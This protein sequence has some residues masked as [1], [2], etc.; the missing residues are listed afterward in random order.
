MAH[1]LINGDPLFTL[2]EDG[3]VQVETTAGV[4]AQVD[5]DEAAALSAVRS[6]SGG[7]GTMGGG[8][9]D[10]VL[11]L[12]SQWYPAEQ[13]K[14]LLASL[15]SKRLIMDR[16]RRDDARR[17]API[18]MIFSPRSG[19]NMLRWLVDTHPNIS[20]PPPSVA[21]HLL[22][23]AMNDVNSGASFRSL[24]SPREWTRAMLRGWA[25]EQMN[26]AARKAGKPRWCHRIWTTY[27][28]L[29][30]VDELF[31]GKPLYLF[32]V[33]HA[34]D[35]VDAACKVYVPAETWQAGPNGVEDDYFTEHGGAYPMAYTRMWAEISR[36]MLEFRTL[37]PDRVFVLR[38]EDLVADPDQALSKMFGF[39][40]EELP[41]GLTDKAFAAPPKML[42]GWQGHEVTRTKKVESDHVGLW[43]SWDPNVVKACAPLVNDLLLAWGYD[44]L[45]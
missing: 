28:V 31:G 18:F 7:G 26:E 35:V 20:C 15:E 2:S 6:F 17:T 39:F 34:L 22:L 12:M 13:S 16:D 21:L 29:P 36:R 3:E 9:S 27:S 11:K 10:R 38:Y 33:R 42:P 8:S 30:Y 19:S 25:E 24:R 14:A 43:K 37:H 23:S 1:W 41:K 4:R 40:G 45:L 32:L 44:S 5:L